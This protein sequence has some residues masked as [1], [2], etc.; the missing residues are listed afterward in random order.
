[1][2]KE[3]QE[4]TETEESNNCAPQAGR[5]EV[6]I[7]SRGDGGAQCEV[8]VASL[9]LGRHSGWGRGKPRAGA[10]AESGMVLSH[11][12]WSLCFRCCPRLSGQLSLY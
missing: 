8:F 5:K 7:S 3:G 6:C 4:D 11:V 10:S 2:K 1:M 12:L 9:W